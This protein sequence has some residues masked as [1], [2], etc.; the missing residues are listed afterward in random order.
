MR[1]VSGIH[2]GAICRC[3]KDAWLGTSTDK[4]GKE[5]HSFKRVIGTNG[6]VCDTYELSPSKLHGKIKCRVAGGVSAASAGN[7]TTF[8]TAWLDEKPCT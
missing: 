4:R 2:A 7:Y 6:C 3:N 1:V 5:V 8:S